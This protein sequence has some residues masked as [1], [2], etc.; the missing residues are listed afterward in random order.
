MTDPFAGLLPSG[1]PALD[2]KRF[3]LTVGHGRT[4]KH[5]IRVAR[6]AQRLADCYGADAETAEFAA[7]AHD[8]G[9]VVP[10]R[11]K[12]ALARQMGIE[13]GTVEQRKPMLLHGPIAAAVLAEK[14]EVRDED[15]LNAVRYHTTLRAGASKLEK[16]VFLAD[17]IAFD[18]SADHGGVYLAKLEARPS[19]DGKALVYLEFV[20]D[21][22]GQPG[23]IVHPNAIAAYRELV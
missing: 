13:V 1:E 19:L 6:V 22:A 16:I 5:V 15:V 20:L 21:Q 4:L 9:V 17:K 11:D 2:V 18:P 7:L 8:L 12:L 14:L 10:D 23:W 3:Y